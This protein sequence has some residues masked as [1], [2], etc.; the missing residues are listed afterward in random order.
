MSFR[1]LLSAPP[2][3]GCRVPPSVPARPSARPRW[4][5]CA[6]AARAHA[7]AP[8][9]GARCWPGAGDRPLLSFHFSSD[10]SGRGRC[11]PA[12]NPACADMPGRNVQTAPTVDKSPTHSTSLW[13]A[14][15]GSVARP[16]LPGYR[17]TRCACRTAFVV[18]VEAIQDKANSPVPPGQAGGYFLSSCP[19]PQASWHGPAP[20]GQSP[21]VSGA[22][23][24]KH[25][26][27]AA[28]ACC[29]KA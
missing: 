12:P 29:A 9:Y 5:C 19:A 21:E 24:Q 10:C 15:A 3:A 20:L 6:V 14:P 8:R 2:K 28:V 13:M 22:V 7:A 1:R 4:R 16:P 18:G 17:L 11:K 27:Q 25:R 26:G 23:G